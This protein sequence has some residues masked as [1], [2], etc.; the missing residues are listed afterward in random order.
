LENK[1]SKKLAS[2]NKKKFGV[3]VHTRTWKTGDFV[4]VNNYDVTGL[5]SPY[6]GFFIRAVE[7]EETQ[8]KIFPRYKVYALDMQR[9]EEVEGYSLELI[10]AAD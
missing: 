8:V 6:Y 3:H 1:N 2:K 5:P 9:E 7:E 4:K 10:S